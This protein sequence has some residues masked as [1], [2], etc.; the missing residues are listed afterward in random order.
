MMKEITN[1]ALRHQLKVRARRPSRIKNPR[2]CGVIFTK[3]LGAYSS[4]VQLPLGG[5]MICVTQPG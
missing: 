3:P 2:N 4:Y 5:V 1:E